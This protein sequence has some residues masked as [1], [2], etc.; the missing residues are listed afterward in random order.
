MSSEQLT[1]A[2]GISPSQ[3]KLLDGIMED[4]MINLPL[5]IYKGRE[6]YVLNR[7]H[8]ASEIE[9]LDVEHIKFLDETL[10][11]ALDQLELVMDIKL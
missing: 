9:E 4:I 7:L 5:I 2:L 11:S 6:R 3:K 8:L 1:I 10:N